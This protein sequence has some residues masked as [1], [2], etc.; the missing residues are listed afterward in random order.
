MTSQRE[1]LEKQKRITLRYKTRS[2]PRLSTKSRK[3]AAKLEQTSKDR[4]LHPAPRRQVQVDTPSFHPK[5]NANSCK[6][7]DTEL[8]RAHVR[9]YQES[10]LRKERRERIAAEELR[11]KAELEACTFKPK[12]NKYHGRSSLVEEE[13]DGKVETRLGLW[14]TRR[15]VNNSQNS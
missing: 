4:L 6:I 13:D 7:V 15:K 5:I 2:I 11:T 9:L 1:L 14:E 3:I 12:L 8:G 10:V